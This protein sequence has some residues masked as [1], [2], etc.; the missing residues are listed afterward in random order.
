M[1]DPGLREPQP[2]DHAARLI[3]ATVIA[4]LDNF[5]INCLFK[6]IKFGFSSDLGSFLNLGKKIYL[7]S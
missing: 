6:I 4:G 5:W 2:L 1:V 3:T 7:N